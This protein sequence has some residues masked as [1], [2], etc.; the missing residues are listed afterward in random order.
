MKDK[1]QIGLLSVIAIAL[2]ALA[3]HQFSGGSA[4]DASSVVAS[5]SIAANV[6]PSNPKTLSDK[7]FDPMATTA[8]P[9]DNTPKTTVNFKEYEHDFG[10]IKQDSENKKIFTFTNTGKEPMIIETANGSCGCTVP[11][12]PKAPIP[13]GGTGEIEVVYKPGKQENAQTKTVTVI[14]NTEPKETTLRIKAN[15]EKVPGADGA[16]AE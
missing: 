9:V 11:N 16:K 7:P 10:N 8:E 3:Y 6:D 12:Y 4:S 15:V 5:N 1:V 2:V 14:A 13:P